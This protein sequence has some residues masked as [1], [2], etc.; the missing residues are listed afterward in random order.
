MRTKLPH[1]ATFR[2][3]AAPRTAL[4]TPPTYG[5]HAAA[6]QHAD[7]TGFARDTLLETFALAR[8]G[9][10][11]SRDL[12][13][14]VGVL[15][16]STASARTALTALADYPSAWRYTCELADNTVGAARI[17][18]LTL[19]GLVA[20]ARGNLPAANTALAAARAEGASVA[21]PPLLRLLTAALEMMLPPAHVQPISGSGAKALDARF[22]IALCRPVA[23]SS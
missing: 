21:T 20:Y 3:G 13:A 9:Q 4:A 23:A 6:M 15:L 12:A 14:R 19:A 8:I 7:P 11:P 10:A 18:L 22:G 2:H 16:D 1:R 5:E 17:H